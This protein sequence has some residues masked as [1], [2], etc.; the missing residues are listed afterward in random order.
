VKVKKKKKQARAQRPPS[1][2][3][4]LFGPILPTK[5][6]QDT[7]TVRFRDKRVTKGAAWGA[8]ARNRRRVSPGFRSAA[9]SVPPHQSQKRT[10]VSRPV[11]DQAKARE[12]RGL[13]FDARRERQPRRDEHRRTVEREACVGERTVDTRGGWEEVRDCRPWTN[14]RAGGKK[15]TRSNW[16][17]ERE[18]GGGGKVGP[19]R[20][21]ENGGWGIFAKSEGGGVGAEGEGKGEGEGWGRR[22]KAEEAAR[23]STH[24]LVLAGDLGRGR[25]S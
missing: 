19:F 2:A 17:L 1:R 10:K 11:G 4:S 24:L 25:R 6:E 18:W 21:R 8:R 9:R 12:D 3:E 16:T 22:G 7:K 15:G 14:H 13:S 20:R 23:L 5:E